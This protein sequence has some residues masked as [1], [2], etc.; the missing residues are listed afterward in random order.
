MRDAVGSNAHRAV[1]R[2][3]PQRCSTS[4]D[5]RPRLLSLGP[6]WCARRSAGSVRRA[7]RRLHAV[8]SDNS[9]IVLEAGPGPALSARS[10]SAASESLATLST[11]RHRQ[12]GC[13]SPGFPPLWNRRPICAG[14]Q[15]AHRPA[16]CPALLPTGRYPRSSTAPGCERRSVRRRTHRRRRCGR[17]DSGWWRP[18]TNWRNG[19]RT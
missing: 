18:S 3:V 8:Q 17:P 15:T 2:S 5:R 16:R 6:G 14:I 4:M 13:P 1:S 7:R 11:A 19:V 12:P 10:R 9:V